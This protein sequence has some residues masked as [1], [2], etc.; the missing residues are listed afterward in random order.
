MQHLGCVKSGRMKQST[1]LMYLGLPLPFL[2]AGSTY[3]SAP[4]VKEQIA[5]LNSRIEE[6]SLQIKVLQNQ[7]DEEIAAQQAANLESNP[8]LTPPSPPPFKGPKRNEA[9]NQRD[10]PPVKDTFRSG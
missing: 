5:E 3:A 7:L 1:L 4:S 9:K 6:L 10:V 8:T 2:F